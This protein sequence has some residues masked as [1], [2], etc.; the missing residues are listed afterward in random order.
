MTYEQGFEQGQQ[1]AYRERKAGLP[2][3]DFEKP[4]NAVQRGY[5]DGYTPQSVTWWVVARKT[6]SEQRIEAGHELA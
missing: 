2:M 3:R 6:L 5:L 4:R 1:D